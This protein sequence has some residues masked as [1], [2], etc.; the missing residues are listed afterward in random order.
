MLCGK[1]T[2]LRTPFPICDDHAHRL[3]AFLLSEYPQR[4]E[5]WAERKLAEMDESRRRFD[6]EEAKRKA[7]RA[8][9]SVVY[10]LRMGDHVKIG[11]SCNVDARIRALYG[12]PEDLLATEPG[13]RTVE[14][15]R[16]REFAAERV[17]PDRELFNPS[18]RLLAHIATL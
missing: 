13:D 7:L 11:T 9:L 2:M 16:H 6:Q 18:P 17:R 12:N 10:Y 5:T 3:Y 1:Q 15:H 14:Q 8:G 4:D